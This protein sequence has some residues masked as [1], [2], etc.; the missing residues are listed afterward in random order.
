MY[1]SS[2]GSGVMVFAK[3]PRNPLP[4]SVAKNGEGAAV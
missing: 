4:G 1:R 3:R 2:Y